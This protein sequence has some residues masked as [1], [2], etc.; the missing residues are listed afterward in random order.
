MEW[1]GSTEIYSG[2][3]VT[4][5]LEMRLRNTRIDTLVILKLDDL[6]IR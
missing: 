2:Q 5:G 6:Q 3:L 4:I 1:K